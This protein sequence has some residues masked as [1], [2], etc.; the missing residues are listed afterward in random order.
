MASFAIK[1]LR[2]RVE[3]HVV[4][5]LFIV[6]T[7]LRDVERLIVI[8]GDKFF[9][10]LNR[11]A[12]RIGHVVRHV[13]ADDH[14]PAAKIDGGDIFSHSGESRLRHHNRAIPHGRQTLENRSF[15]WQETKTVVQ[16]CPRPTLDPLI[17]DRVDCP[18]LD[19]GAPSRIA[20]PGAK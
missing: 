17:E 10:L 13:G 16:G 14:G 5:R 4:R 6:G 7:Q 9:A 8:R 1:A 19:G 15:H 11:F 3:R 12:K 2:A 18:A 20:G